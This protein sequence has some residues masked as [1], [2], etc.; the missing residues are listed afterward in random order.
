MGRRTGGWLVVGAGA[1][2]ALTSGDLHAN[3]SSATTAAAPVERSAPHAA[4]EANQAQAFT[5]KTDREVLR[6]A[7]EAY[8]AIQA[9]C[10]ARTRRWRSSTRVSAGGAVQLHDV[11]PGTGAVLVQSPDCGVPV[12]PCPKLSAAKPAGPGEAR[13]DGKAGAG[14]NN[15]GGV[16]R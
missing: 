16:D 9:V 10:P 14:D 12:L 3:S 1:V 7:V 5:C 4:P 13:R 8:V 2:L 11:E 15:R 6:T